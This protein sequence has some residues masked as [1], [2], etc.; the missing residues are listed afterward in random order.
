VK[1]KEAPLI[2]LLQSRSQ[3]VIPIYQRTYSWTT[4]QCYRLWQD[5]VA[6]GAH[7]DGA[8]H[9]IGSIVYMDDPGPITTIDKLLVIDGQQRLTTLTLLLVAMRNQIEETGDEQSVK[10]RTISDY[11][12]FN[13]AEDG[14]DRYK[15]LLTQR[16][17]DTLISLVD[18]VPEPPDASRRVHEN[19]EFFAT[20]IRQTGVDLSQ[21]YSGILKLTVVDVSLDPHADNPQLIFESLN[22]TG[23]ALTQADLIRNYILMQQPAAE[24]ENLYTNY[25]LKMEQGFGQAHYATHFDAFMRHY[26]TLKLGRIPRIADIYAEFKKYAQQSHQTTRELVSDIY[27][28]ATYYAQI[29]LGRGEDREIQRWLNE[30]NELRIDTAY[31]LLLEV[32]ADYANERATQADVIGILRLIDSYV[33]RR[34]ICGIPT[35]SLNR[36]FQGFSRSIDKSR[37]LESAAATFQLLDGFR[38]FPNDE[39]FKRAFVDRD[40][41]NLTARRN[42]VLRRLENYDRKEPVNVESFTIEHI[43]PQN[44][45]LT[46]AWQEAL[47]PDWKRIQE[48]YLHT[49]GNLTLTGYNS[50]LSDRSFAEKR[51]MSGGFQDSPIRLNRDFAKL[52]TWDEAAI[53]TRAARLADL[54]VQV[55]PAPHLPAST[56]AVYRPPEPERTVRVRTLA[57]H[58]LLRNEVLALFESLRT[59]ILNIDAS[60]T[61]EIRSRYIAFKTTTNF[62]DVIPRRNRLKLTM[63]LDLYELDDPQ[64]ICWAH[65]SRAYE[66][67]GGAAF[68]VRS[69]DGLD[70]AMYLI[71]QSFDKHAEDGD[72]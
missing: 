52:E 39:E 44:E 58:P 5:I 33:F 8:S 27:Q 21:I 12:L 72:E 28:Y 25:W 10:L 35:N 68:E 63:N 40:I 66:G 3:F 48:T 34:A 7:S 17:R 51:M 53:Q 65:D 9:F 43:M 14:A 61:E 6:A 67:N 69:P 29:A 64:G 70:Y 41:Y 31:P 18:K 16:D 50:E 45:D 37:Y 23:L 2:R 15:L 42:Y 71:H 38:R 4:A 56:V 19:L 32:F 22:S 62:V 60:V 30:I 46:P 24:Q 20:Q 49:I 1:A 47:G 36:T 55:W 13:P 26:L 54:A 57:D 11:Y 59:R